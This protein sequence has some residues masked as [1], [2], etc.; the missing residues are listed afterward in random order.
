MQKSKTQTGF[1]GFIEK[2]IRK[3]VIIYYFIRTIAIKFDIFERRFQNFK[4]N[5]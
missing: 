5:F 3:F 2:Y 1:L 4:K